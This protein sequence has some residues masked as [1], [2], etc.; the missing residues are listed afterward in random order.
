MERPNLLV[1]FTLDDRRYALHLSAVDRAVRIADITPLPRAPDIVLGV[2]NVQGRVIP[3]VNVRKRFRL[4]EREIAL[5]DQLI[6]AHTARRPVALVADG[7][8]GVIE[9][10]E[11]DLVGAESVLPGV[12]YLEGVA[13]LKD[14]LVLIH[15]L[16]RFL[17]LDE[18]RSLDRAMKAT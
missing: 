15:N 1:V 9:Y 10:L 11:A 2:V 7:M 17:S 16:D 5:T 4:P 18:E 14:G 6:I 12:E 8:T 13:K 3:V